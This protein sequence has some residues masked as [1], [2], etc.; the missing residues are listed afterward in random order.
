MQLERDVKRNKKT[1]DST[2]MWEDNKEII[3]AVFRRW[4][5][6]L[7]DV[8]VNS[9]VWNAFFASFSERV[10]HDQ[11]INLYFIMGSFT[12]KKWA[13][14]YLSVFKLQARPDEIYP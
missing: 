14:T 13:G 6:L 2:L 11:M 8:T 5:E 1:L 3:V 10:K 9:E 12:T 4:W 7:M